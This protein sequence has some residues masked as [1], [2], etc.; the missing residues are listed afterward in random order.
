MIAMLL[1]SGYIALSYN[2]QVVAN[3]FDRNVKEVSIDNRSISLAEDNTFRMYSCKDLKVLNDYLMSLKICD[4]T[5]NNNN[6][7][8]D[9]KSLYCYYQADEGLVVVSIDDNTFEY[10]PLYTAGRKDSHTYFLDEQID[11]GYVLSLIYL[12][13]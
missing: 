11:W 10:S 7:Y 1:K 9:G 3:V 8:N 5:G 2:H 6:N 12:L 13:P 4:I